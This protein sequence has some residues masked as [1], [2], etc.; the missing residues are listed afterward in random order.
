MKNWLH[1]GVISIFG[2][3]MAFNGDPLSASCH[4]DLSQI[5]IDLFHKKNDKE[6]KTGKKLLSF[7]AFELINT[8]KTSAE[9][10]RMFAV[11]RPQ[12]N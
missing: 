5:S 1:F 7:M 9:S 2:K 4:F 8:E 6:K 3:I 10:H 11:K 12:F